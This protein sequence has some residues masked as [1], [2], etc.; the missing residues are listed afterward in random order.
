MIRWP[1]RRAVE[2]ACHHPFRE[3]TADRFYNLMFCDDLELARRE[4][5]PLSGPWRLLME[6][7]PRSS[8][9]RTLATAEHA[10]SRARALA[11]ALLRARGAPVTPASTL[12][13]V[14]EVALPEGPELLAAYADGAVRHLD[15]FGRA[16]AFEGAPAAVQA[17]AR[18]IVARGAAF[19]RR[20]A[21]W[22]GARLPPPRCGDV[23]VS[24]LGTDGLRFIEGSFAAL[25]ADA[26]IAAIIGG[27]VRLLRQLQ[28]RDR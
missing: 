18:D 1:F 17:L 11:A 20:R 26:D 9:L 19:G 16:L 10:D 28:R 5:S 24:V 15:A 13:V 25:Q 7:S 12:G 3:A 21:I 23:R 6:P 22:S 4:P 27:A 2:A 14:V 8:A